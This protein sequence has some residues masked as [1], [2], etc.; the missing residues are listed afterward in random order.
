M[1]E[2]I[3]EAA[4]SYLELSSLHVR[5]RLIVDKP[6]K[7]REEKDFRLVPSPHYVTNCLVQQSA[8]RLEDWVD[9]VCARFRNCQGIPVQD[10]LFRRGSWLRAVNS[11]DV[12]RYMVWPEQRHQ[13][14]PDSF[15][16]SSLE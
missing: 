6:P 13:F 11:A 9:V 16:T 10:G 7:A 3:T 1:A 4:L 2:S 15:L 14:K 5:L 12:L 8:L